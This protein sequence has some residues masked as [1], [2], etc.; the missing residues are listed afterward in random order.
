MT[1]VLLVDD[2]ELIR[3]GL[4]RAFER[5]GSMTV[6]GQ[7]ASVAEAPARLEDPAARRRRHRPPAAGRHRARHRASPPGRERR[8]GPGDADD[9]HRRRPDLRGHGGRCLGVPEQ[10]G[11]R[12]RGR[13]CGRPRR[14]SAPELPVQ[15]AGRSGDAARV[16]RGRPPDP[17]E[18][19][20]SW[21]CSRTG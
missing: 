1:N 19:R 6:V 8:R 7:A 16:D 3:Q 4:A 10:G 15:R 20:R 13:Q 11:A 5:D 18:S 2:H 21:S 14:Q 9:A 17:R 12:R